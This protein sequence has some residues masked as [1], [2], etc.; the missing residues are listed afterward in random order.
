MPSHV[1]AAGFMPRTLVTMLIGLGLA[2]MVDDPM[3]QA[4]GENVT[5]KSLP[6]EE[7]VI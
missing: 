3:A 5:C 4:Q 1:N 2:G 7:F 6:V